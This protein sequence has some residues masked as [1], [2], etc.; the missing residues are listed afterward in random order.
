VKLARIA[1]LLAG[2]VA[3]LLAQDVAPPRAPAKPSAVTREMRDMRHRLVLIQTRAIAYFHSMDSIEE[4]LRSQG[5]VLHPETVVLRVRIEAELGEA[6][7]AL[8][9]DDL[10]EAG[11]ALDQAQSL[12]DR[13]AAKLGG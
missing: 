12:L 7:A 1:L 2:L 8:D 9:Q 11:E 6:R 3:P 13:L 10:A 4:R 5:M